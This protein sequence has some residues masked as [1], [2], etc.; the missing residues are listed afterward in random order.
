MKSVCIETICDFE[1]STLSVTVVF[2]QTT[3]VKKEE[4]WFLQ[5][6]EIVNT[7][8]KKTWLF[9][10]NQWFSLYHGDGQVLREFFPVKSSKTGELC[11]LLGISFCNLCHT[12]PWISHGV[13]HGCPITHSFYVVNTLYCMLWVSHTH[14]FSWGF[15]NSVGVPTPILFMGVSK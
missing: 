1:L 2:W 5:E 3:A 7:K 9:T 6:I 4:A 11:C 8:T 15:L 12:L 13:L 10:C 14:T